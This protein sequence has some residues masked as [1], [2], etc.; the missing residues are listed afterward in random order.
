MLIYLCYKVSKG[1]HFVLKLSV[2]L[3]PKLAE[4]GV[5]EYLLP[6][7]ALILVLGLAM[8]ITRKEK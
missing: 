1:F 3:Q 6:S 8:K 4:T 5:E 7:A 2:K